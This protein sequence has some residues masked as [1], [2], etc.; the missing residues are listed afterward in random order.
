MDRETTVSALTLQ[1]SASCLLCTLAYWFLDAELSPGGLYPPV[2][3]VYGPLL[4]GID[5]LFLQQERTLQALCLLNGGAAVAFAAAG[6]PLIGWGHWTSLLFSAVACIW[7]SVWAGQ[8]ALEPPPLVRLLLYLDVSLI[9]SVLFVGYASA[10]Q[11]PAYQ[12]IPACLGCAS[13]LLGLTLRRVGRG[14]GA[15]GWGFIAAA[16]LVILAL[17]VLLVGVAAAPAGY[18][19]VALW[20]LLTQVAHFLFSLLGKLLIWLSSLIPP[21]E[22]GELP[23]EEPVIFEQLQERELPQSNPAVL[24]VLIVLLA[25]GALVLLIYLLKLL[26]RLRVGGRKVKRQS[27]P[28]R[29]RISLTAGL[30]RLLSSWATRLRLRLYLFRIRSTPEGSYYLLVRKCRMAPWHKRREET[31]REFLLRLYAAAGGDCQLTAALEALIPAVDLALYAPNRSGQFFP[32]SKLVRR[33]IGSAARK[34]FLR[35]C[36]ARIPLFQPK[37]PQSDQ[38]S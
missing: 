14:L 29:R 9:F 13:A 12:L 22:P 5:R 20:D 32:Q 31:P 6:I 36:L 19:V 21:A 38:T 15:K 25:V 2:L 34:Q 8:M 28:L 23:A 37:E 1:M 24:V 35:D 26:G 30:R 16:F 7:L 4:Y 33:R 10:F 11:R 17:V 3:L 27:L 18:G